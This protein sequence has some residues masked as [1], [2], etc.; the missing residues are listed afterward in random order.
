LTQ[1][2]TTSGIITEIKPP[3][4]LR[5]GPF[6]YTIDVVE[7]PLKLED[8]DESDSDKPSLLMGKTITHSQK[9]E[10]LAGMPYEVERETLFHEILHAIYSMVGAP[11]DGDPHV[12]E[13]KLVQM[14]S[15]PIV[16][17]FDRNPELITYMFGTK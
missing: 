12:G 15:P 2:K 11:D 6:I 16:D 13:E 1:K 7:G 17:I 8:E 4:T 10:I 3:S 14:F 5:V 9:I